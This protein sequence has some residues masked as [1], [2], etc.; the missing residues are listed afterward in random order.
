MSGHHSPHLND[1]LMCHALEASAQLAT[2][3]EQQ[4]LADSG[5]SKENGDAPF[6]KG[7]A[8]LLLRSTLLAAY[9]TFESAR[10]FLGWQAFKRR[11]TASDPAF[12][13]C[14]AV[15]TS[16]SHVACRHQGLL[17]HT[18]TGRVDQPPECKGFFLRMSGSATSLQT[19]PY[20]RPRLEF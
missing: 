10:V 5:A 6:D 15:S 7:I 12:T 16:V 2:L 8:F 4:L 13:E 9:C 20:T 3:V 19:F 14:H 18:A 11:V 1:L 17:C